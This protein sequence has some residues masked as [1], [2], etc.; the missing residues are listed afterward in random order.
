MVTDRNMK[1]MRLFRILCILL[2]FTLLGTASHAQESLAGRVYYNTNIFDKKFKD[3]LKDATK[4]IDKDMAEARQKTIADKEKKLGR[5]L[6]EKELKEVDEKMKEAEAVL[7]ALA[8]GTK[9]AVTVEFKSE[10]QLVV[11]AVMSIDEEELKKNGVGWVTRKALKAAISMS[12]MTEKGTYVVK[13]SQIFI[14]SG[15]EKDTMSLS[16]DGQQLFGKMD[17]DEF[18]LKRI[19]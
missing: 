18:T 15:K 17:E 14:T 1:T 3:A 2:A 4:D 7:R 8:E 12:S 9:A 19:K 10:K 16:A 5:P 11:K 13:D 6:N